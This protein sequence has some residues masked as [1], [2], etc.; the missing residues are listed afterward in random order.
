SDPR[1]VGGAAN[2]AAVH[3]AGPVT[4]D[5][6]AAKR[7]KARIKNGS[8]WRAL[9]DSTYTLPDVYPVRITELH[10]HPADGAGVADSDDMEFI[11]LFNTGNQ[12]VSLAGVQI[13]QFA[14]TPY[15]FGNINL[16]AGQRIIVARTPAVFQSVYG[17]GLNVAPLGYATANL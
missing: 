2:P 12:T 16:A 10:Y 13:T 6:D 15:T 5:I 17:S 9:I 1:L 11:E 8:E 3:S 4:V 14:T 7:I